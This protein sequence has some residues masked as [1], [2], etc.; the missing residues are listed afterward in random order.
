MWNSINMHIQTARRKDLVHEIA[1]ISKLSI[2]KKREWKRKRDRIESDEDGK[3]AEKKR[4]QK[5][6]RIL[7][8]L[9]PAKRMK[10]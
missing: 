5:M 8:L 4:E 10:N 7:W 2:E 3:R 9:Y 6:L 1:R